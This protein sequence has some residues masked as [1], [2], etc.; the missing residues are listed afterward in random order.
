MTTEVSMKKF[1]TMQE[2]GE[3]ERKAC[4]DHETRDF[5]IV[6]A[7]EEI[8]RKVQSR[9][10]YP[11]NPY[12]FDTE[13][14]WRAAEVEE[15]WRFAKEGFATV[16]RAM[17]VEIAVFADFHKLTVDW[18]P[19][20]ESR[21]KGAITER[22]YLDEHE[23]LFMERVGLRL[24]QEGFLTCTETELRTF[25][26]AESKKNWDIVGA[27][28]TQ[29]PPKTMTPADWQEVCPQQIEFAR[30]ILHDIVRHYARS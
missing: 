6:K 8:G 10:P 1:R 22:A 23:R 14:E 18:N 17:Y 24:L 21:Y 15:N 25:F 7:S 4:M 28:P 5:Q 11:G 2:M 20:V 30:G 19:S 3:E 29:A 9:D 13:E 12:S 16:R 27:H 26:R